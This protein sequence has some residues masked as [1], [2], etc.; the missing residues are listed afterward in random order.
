MKLMILDGNSIINRAFYGVRLLTTREGLYTNAIFGFLNIL[1]KLRNEEQPDALAVAF[2]LK[3]PTF[4]HLQYEGY[5]ATRHAMPE[6]LAQQMPLMKDVLRAMN[7]PIFEC[8]GWEADDILGTAGRICA[9][10]DWDCVI[11]TG[12][13]DSLQLV[14]EHVSVK[15]VVTRGGQTNTTLYTPEVFEAEYGFA[16]I[17]MIDLK[18]LMGD[19]SDNIPGVAGVGPKTATQLLVQYGT[20][21]GVYAHLDE[22]KDSV[23][24]KLEAGRENAYLSYDLATIRCEAPVD[25]RPEDCL[26]REA[27]NDALWALFQKLEFSRLAARYHLHPPKPAEPEVYEGECQSEIVTDAARAEALLRQFAEKERV[28]LLF[29]ADHSSVAVMDDGDTAWLFSRKALGEG[30]EA[31]LRGL[32]AGNIRK[33]THDVKETMRAL[34]EQGLPIEGFCFDTALAGYLLDATQGSYTV[35]RMFVQYCGSQIGLADEK[36]LGEAAVTANLFAR[37]AAVAALYAVLPAKLEA[38]GMQELYFDMELPLCAVL[39]RM[40]TAGVLVDQLALVAFGN[41]LSERITAC[42]ELIFGYAGGEFNI[43]SPKQLGELLFEKLGLPAMKKTKSGYSTNAEVLEKLKNKHPIVQAILDYRMLAK[44]KSTYADGL[45][46]EIADDGRIH[47]TF[48][49]MVT[50]TGRLSST[51]PNLQ[52]IPVRT[53]LGSEIRRM[54]VPADGCVFVDADYS[55]IEL[56][57]LAHIAD[58]ARMQEAFR[59]GMDVHTA[60]AAQVFGVEPEQVT[61]LQR[62]HAKAVNFGIVYGISEFSLAEDIGVTRK[63][64]K[65]YIESYLANYSGV[66]AYMHDIVA[67]AKAD[68]YVTT[69]FGRRR[70]LPEL[71]SSNFNIRSFGERVALN[72]P[73]QGTA[74]DIIKLAMLHVDTALRQAKLRARLILQVHDE[75][76]V[77]CPVEESETVRKLVAEQMEHVMTLKVPLLAEAKIGESWYAAK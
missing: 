42:Q 55:Q 73:I 38:Q 52:N 50:A 4:R 25:F 35:D 18:S 61:P 9:A 22:L 65:A 46:K 5:K 75:L 11:V 12:D 41:M 36:E 20:L 76:I 72:T 2:D 19:S 67:K 45:V 13:R 34:L 26:V 1:E 56:R 58:D 43:N 15:L 6:E 29:S 60:T 77:E 3:A 31:F 16:P 53:E 21:D 47:T 57:V 40:E 64:A 54:F 69:L 27:D 70:D 59:S 37:T 71:K 24:K 44:L 49:N 68:G 66:R 74:A 30:Y 8:E 51:E 39:A 17:R 62:R 10:S 7:I 63:E 48:Q 23:R 33:V 32:C 14:A 28:F